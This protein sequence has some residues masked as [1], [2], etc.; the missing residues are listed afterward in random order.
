LSE[1]CHDDRLFPEIDLFQFTNRYPLQSEPT[2]KTK[3][4]FSPTLINYG[5][6]RDQS[7]ELDHPVVA[8]GAYMVFLMQVRSPRFRFIP[9]RVETSSSS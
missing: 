3:F 7:N 1:S 6:R 5:H 8:L 9:S 2:Q 4:T